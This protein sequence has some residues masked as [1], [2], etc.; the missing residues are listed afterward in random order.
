MKGGTF[1]RNIFFK[2]FLIFF[3]LII[4]FSGYSQNPDIHSFNIQDDELL[5]LKYIDSL[6]SRDLE[7]AYSF[8]ISELSSNIEKP[9]Y[10]TSLLSRA[11]NSSFLLG[12]IND[13]DSL[14][15]LLMNFSG[16]NYH[17]ILQAK[18][19]LNQAKAAR[20]QKRF[21]NALELVKESL[22]N[23]KN[24]GDIKGQINAINILIRIYFDLG[25]YENAIKNVPEI[26]K[27]IEQSTDN[28]LR[29]DIL[30]NISKLYT[31]LGNYSESQ[32]FLSRAQKAIQDDNLK[33]KL[34]K[35]Y[36]HQALLYYMQE[37]YTK[38]L[39]YF[40]KSANEKYKLGK[41]ISLSATIT[42][43]AAIAMHQKKY[44]L[45]EYYNREALKIRTNAKNRYL[46]GSSH[47]N[48]AKCLVFQ[49]KFDSAQY[50]IS[51]AEELFSVYQAKP[52]IKRGNLLM[53]KI[54]LLQK[55]YKNAYKTLQKI[56]SIEDSIYQ[57]K[58]RIKLS[59]LESG[60]KV[61]KYKQE[62]TELKIKSIQEKNQNEIHRLLIKIS[63]IVLSFVI[64]F[65]YILFIHI[66]EKN[67]RKLQLV[68]QKMIFIQ[69]NSHFVF[70]ALTAIQSLLY[71]RQI[72]SAIHY[73][74]IFSN[75]VRKVLFVTDKKYIG[76]QME[77]SFIM[78]FLQLQKLRFGND[79][80]YQIDISDILLQLNLKVPP[81][82]LYPYI[83]YAVEECVQRSEEKSMLIIKVDSDKNHIVYRLIDV[84]LGFSNLD[85][86]YI[87]RFAKEKINCFELTNQR[88][89]MYNQFFKKRLAFSLEAYHLN[90]D[91]YPAL[92][93][94]IRK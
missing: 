42:L 2:M 56:I 89:K 80:K 31:Y 30:I 38:A 92:T 74:A 7:L 25:N 17:P 22:L 61:S 32:I 20:C 21:M 90:G 91:N 70:N 13:L 3:I 9:D 49:H 62:K 27:L 28:E 12:Y 1:K 84:D 81:L 40:D 87:K 60:I 93:F 4:Q 18:I 24:N 34:A 65:S 73:L 8:T 15:R 58:N 75:M 39:R 50:Q 54:F 41:I 23:F 26:E 69:M 44:S 36:N 85:N 57:H 76:L 29:V 6:I 35:L 66:R 11:I 55:D 53:K 79:L 43:K 19:A 33:T 37:N 68:N 78:E 88:I 59:E 16:D 77:V 45:A 47:Y 86:C 82:L 83:E 71:K 5:N 64:L 46:M 14:N 48:I 94:K 67:K 63:L 10:Y 72:E 52:N 51:K